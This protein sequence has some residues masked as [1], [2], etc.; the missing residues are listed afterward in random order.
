MA[1]LAPPP[2][3]GKDLVA[4]TC[5]GTLW[6]PPEGS[7]MSTP[8]PFTCRRFEEFGQPG[9]PELSGIVYEGEYKVAV[10][11]FAGSHCLQLEKAPPRLYK[12]CDLEIPSDRRGIGAALEKRIKSR[13]TMIGI[14]EKRQGPL[15]LV[16]DCFA[17]KG[18]NVWT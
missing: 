18:A 10:S 3:C 12:T 1:L 9:L 17:M 15:G 5:S 4:V 16:F 8:N 14:R 7:K 2:A 13:L 11:P 6:E